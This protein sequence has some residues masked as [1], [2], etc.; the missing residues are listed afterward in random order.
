MIGA[1]TV[2]SGQDNSGQAAIVNS[3]QDNSF[4]MNMLNLIARDAADKKRKA[5]EGEKQ[6][7]AFLTDISVQYDPFAVEELDKELA[8]SVNALEDY[9]T[10]AYAAGLDPSN[11]TTDAGKEYLQMKRKID[12]RNI[13]G[14]TSA[15]A[16]K[17]ALKALDE[18]GVDPNYTLGWLKGYRDAKPQANESVAEA[19]ARYVSENPTFVK[20]LTGMYDYVSPILENINYAVN[21][22]GDKTIDPVEVG[23]LIDAQLLTPQG[24]MLFE[25]MSPDR[26]WNKFRQDQ[27][28]LVMAAFPVQKGKEGKA[29]SGGS[30]KPSES[31]KWELTHTDSPE[32]FGYDKDNKENN[33]SVMNA[34][35]LYGK[36]SGVDPYKDVFS[37]M[38]NGKRIDVEGIPQAIL[39]RGDGQLVL[40]VSSSKGG[41]SDMSVIMGGVSPSGSANVETRWIPLTGQNE[42]KIRQAFGDEAVDA[43]MDSGTSSEPSAGE[44]KEQRIARIKAAA[45]GKK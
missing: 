37:Y 35:K 16:Y 11:P 1:S 3:T 32:A 25:Q 14:K 36:S 26:E 5:D 30:S 19:K 13:T 27:I 33:P 6:K 20:K 39:K 45:A 10:E 8:D 17:S 7:K 44:T 43:L 40:E 31:M 4:A 18:E 12:M 23:R 15:D 2:Y 41:A 42:M 21:T 29:G 22:K 38:E 9:A 28:D 34:V 24:Q